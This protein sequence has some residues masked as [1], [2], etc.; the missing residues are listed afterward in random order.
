MT[1]FKI[2]KNNKTYI[3]KANNC[4]EAITKFNTK[5]KICDDSDNLMDEL[6]K[7]N[8]K[9]DYIRLYYY[10]TGPRNIQITWSGHGGGVGINEVKKFI[11]ELNDTIKFVEQ[12][13]HKYKVRG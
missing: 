4:D 8:E 5:L 7:F 6:D 12:L 9:S 10:R 11:E 2:V 1:N 13:N 3:V